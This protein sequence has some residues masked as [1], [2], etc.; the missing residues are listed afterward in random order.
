MTEHLSPSSLERFPDRS[1][2]A[3]RLLREVR[4]LEVCPGCREAWGRARAAQRGRDPALVV[5]GIDCLAEA[6][7][8]RIEDS[9]EWSRLDWLAEEHLTGDEL[10]AL[11]AGRSNDLELE[12][13]DLHLRGCPDCRR[14]LKASSPQQPEWGA[15][16]RRLALLF[17]LLLLLPVLSF[18]ACLAYYAHPD[19]A[20]VPG[21]SPESSPVEP[22]RPLPSTRQLSGAHRQAISG[23]SEQRGQAAQHPG[24]GPLVIELRDGGRMITLDRAGR[25]TGLPE[26]SRA[27]RRWIARALR[28]G[29]LLA[30]GTSGLLARESRHYRSNT[31]S[32]IRTGPHPVTAPVR[33]S[34]ATSPVCEWKPDPRVTKWRVEL[35]ELGGKAH[36]VSPL[37]DADVVRWSPAE[38]LPR[39]STWR[40]TLRAWGWLGELPPS[41][42]LFTIIG[43]SELALFEQTG[44]QTTSHLARGLLY[45]RLGLILEALV[46]FRQLDSQNPDNLLIKRFML[47]LFAQTASQS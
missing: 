1:V 28:R 22:V 10:T 21:H 13:A 47:Q 32:R 26:L 18:L 3:E 9:V 7:L 36:L 15:R 23:L 44:R 17:V 14:N 19:A 33:L 31:R 11:A 8:L 12:M 35:D 37:L 40:V 41:S 24:G 2:S 25:L 4:H 16:S 27:D 5:P 29:R 46:E 43:E 30:P 38:Q 34:L 6:E 42:R 20:H 39:R 45:A